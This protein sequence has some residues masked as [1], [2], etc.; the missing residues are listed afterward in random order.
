MHDWLLYCVLVICLYTNDYVLKIRLAIIYLAK[1]VQY[2]IK[3]SYKIYVVLYF[4]ISLEIVGVLNKICSKENK[5]VVTNP[6]AR[7]YM[8]EN[9][10]YELF[11]Q[12][13]LN[14]GY[15][16]YATC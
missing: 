4:I 5:T 8:G 15:V 9:D 11:H 10:W 2:L 1:V 7:L 6:I 12:L 13:Q 3:F 16:T 14:L